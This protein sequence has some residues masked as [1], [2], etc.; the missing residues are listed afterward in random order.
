MDISTNRGRGPNVPDNVNNIIAEVYIKDHN[1]TAKEVMGEVH[2]RLEKQPNGQLR[3]DWPGLSYI[4]KALIKFR[5]KERELPLDPEDRPWSVA[6]LALADYNIPPEALP[7]VMKAWAKALVDDKPL[8]IRQVKW[9]ARLRYIYTGETDISLEYLTVKASNYAN[10]EKA[11]KLTGAYPDKPQ[12][13]RWL[14][15]SDAF[16]YIDVKDKDIDVAKRLLATYDI[17]FEV[18][19]G[20]QNERTHN[21]ES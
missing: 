3:P 1:Q 13:M 10:T 7:V 9:I 18:K 5:K 2:R 16:L 6:A 15:L 21:K 12:N 14:W 4:Q 19:K 8:T 17:G 11:I 20:G